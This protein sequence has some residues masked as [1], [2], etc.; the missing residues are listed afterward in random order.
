MIFIN[1]IIFTTNGQTYF[2]DNVSNF[3]VTTKGFKFNYFG[4]ETN[5]K[6]EAFFNS[7]SVSGYSIKE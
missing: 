5:V 3:K 6:R 4:K 1:I 7:L 2:F